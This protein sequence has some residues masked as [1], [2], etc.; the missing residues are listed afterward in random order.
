MVLCYDDV[1]SDSLAKITKSPQNV[2]LLPGEDAILHCSTDAA[3]NP[4]EWRYDGDLVASQPCTPFSDSYNTT[5]PNPATDCN[6]IALAGTGRDISG[7]YLCSDRSNPRA[8][9][10]VITLSE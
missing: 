10:T 7:P 3:N 8:V 2:L 4:I 5:A 9:S 6:L 1:M